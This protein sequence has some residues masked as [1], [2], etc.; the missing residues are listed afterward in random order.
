MAAVLAAVEAE[1][2]RSSAICF[3]RRTYPQVAACH[4]SVQGCRRS[5]AAAGCCCCCHGCCQL[6]LRARRLSVPPG[7]CPVTARTVQGMARVRSGQALAWLLSRDRSARREVCGIKRD[8]G[9][10]VH[11]APFACAGCPAG[12]I[13]LEAAGAGTY[14]QRAI[15]GSDPSHVQGSR[16]R[17]ARS[18]KMSLRPRLRPARALPERFIAVMTRSRAMA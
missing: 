18:L 13:T 17:K 8:F 1:R 9:V 16:S 10:Y 3:S 14:A 11:Q 6:G 15:P 5:P 2:P 4:A 7:Y 12:T